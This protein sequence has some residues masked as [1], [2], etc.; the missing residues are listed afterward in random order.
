[1]EK[2]ICVRENLIITV[3]KENHRFWK[4]WYLLFSLL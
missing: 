1:L 2:V 4:L 3:E